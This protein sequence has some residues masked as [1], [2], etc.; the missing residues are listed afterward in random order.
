MR[1]IFSISSLLLS[2]VIACAGPVEVRPSEPIAEFTI[3]DDWETKRI[4]RGVQAFS[5]DE[6]VYFW[7]EAYNPD[8][9]QQII[10]EHSEYWKKQGV[11]ITSSDEQKHQENGKEVSMTKE[12][13]TWNGKPTVLYYIEFQLGLQSGSN[14]V[15]TYWASPQGD[16]TFQKEVGDVLASLKVT[17]K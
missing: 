10:A 8:E 14:I 7:I 6:E 17:E 13:A 4:D 11:V 1:A 3:P 2:S 5:P 12:H 9:F 15:V 16:K